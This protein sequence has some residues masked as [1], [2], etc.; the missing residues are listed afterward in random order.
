MALV[1]SLVLVGFGADVAVLTV[2]L[3]GRAV[4]R[5]LH[6]AP[7][8]LLPPRLLVVGAL[9]PAR[10]RV[11]APR[12]GTRGVVTTPMTRAGR[13]IAIFGAF[14]APGIDGDP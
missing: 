3:A 11:L 12:R 4:A 1:L 13:A 2:V 7:F 5:R 8:P 6:F 9:P 10:A 14:G